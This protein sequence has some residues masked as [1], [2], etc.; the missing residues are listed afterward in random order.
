VI[1]AIED[2]L[3]TDSMLA[4]LGAGP[5]RGRR[6]RITFTSDATAESGWLSIAE[7]R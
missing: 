1:A 5:F 3:A 2:S 7:S 6:P 4:A